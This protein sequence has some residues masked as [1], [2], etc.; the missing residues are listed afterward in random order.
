MMEKTQAEKERLIAEVT[1]PSKVS[2]Y[3]AT[4]M[5]FGPE[6]HGGRGV[7]PGIGCPKCIFVMYFHDLASTPPEKRGARLDELDEVLH[8]VV[9]EVKAGR[10]DFKP[11]ERAQISLEN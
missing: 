2:L 3:C 8:H 10:W 7:K 6:K 5:Y 9:E 4:H 1:D 11:F